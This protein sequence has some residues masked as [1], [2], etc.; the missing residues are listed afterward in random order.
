[1]KSTAYTITT[2][3]TLI[4]PADDINREVYLHSGT[5]SVYVG[6]TGVTTATGIH[7]PNGSNLTLF[8]PA[9]QTLY[10]IAGSGSHTMVVLTPGVD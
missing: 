7:M 1:M 10:A 9:G 4:C 6:G 2:S 5:G 3:A 8:V